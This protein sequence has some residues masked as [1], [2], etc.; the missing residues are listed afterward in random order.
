MT[1]LFAQCTTPEKWQWYAEMYAHR[2]VFMGIEPEVQT[3]P[4]DERGEWFDARAV[5]AAENRKRDELT[6]QRDRINRAASDPNLGKMRRLNEYETM[7]EAASI[8]NDW[9]RSR[10]YLNFEDYKRIERLDHVDACKLL[11]ASLPGPE[12]TKR[13]PPESQPTG[14]AATLGVKA[15]EVSPEKYRAD[16]IAVGIQPKAVA[17]E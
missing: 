14:Y 4:F 1:K 13:I 6:R 7:A 2:R 17:A 12:D 9:A 8:E 5:D 16:Q 11:I 15:R 3:A 10:R